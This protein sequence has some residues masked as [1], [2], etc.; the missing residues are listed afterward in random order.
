MSEAPGAGGGSDSLLKIPG[1][2]G[3]PGGWGRGGDGSGR[4]FARNWGG[5]G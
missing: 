5:G 1:G 4:V 2:G 3:L